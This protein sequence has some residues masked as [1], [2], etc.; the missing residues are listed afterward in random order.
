MQMPSS[1]IAQTTATGRL[2][3]LHAKDF[4]LG[5]VLSRK[6][7]KYED[8]SRRLASDSRKG[9]LMRNPIFVKRQQTGR[10]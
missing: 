10:P 4:R 6:I 5:M 2:L 7:L 3:P 1:S 9:N 8:V